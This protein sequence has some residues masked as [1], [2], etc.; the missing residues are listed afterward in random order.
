MISENKRLCEGFFEK[1]C[2][3]TA[4]VVDILMKTE[5]YVKEKIDSVKTDYRRQKCLKES[6]FYVTPVEKAMGSRWKTGIATDLDLIDYQI[7]QTTFQQVT[8]SGTIKALFSNPD[9]KNK[10]IEYNNTKHQCVPGIYLDYCCGDISKNDSF[11]QRK[12]TVVLQFGSDE[13]EVCCG[14]KTKATIHKTFGVYFRIRN[15]PIKYASKLHHIYLSALCNSN[16][17]KQSGCGEDNI[18]DEIKDEMLMLERDGIIIENDFRVNVGIFDFTGDNKG[19]NTSCGFAG[20]FN[21]EYFCRYCTS[22]KKETQELT[23]EDVSKTR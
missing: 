17:F 12:N 19:I 21:T 15:M 6:P 7:V 11:F 23:A 9:F 13:F 16:N 14:L 18:W 22:T 5:I 4:D 2:K 1:H 10:F 3:K 20:G 8:I